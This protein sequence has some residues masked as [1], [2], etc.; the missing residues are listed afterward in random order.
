MGRKARKYRISC[1]F[2]FYGQDRLKREITYFIAKELG[3]AAQFI[4][5]NFFYLLLER[6]SGALAAPE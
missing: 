4:A 3:A 1:F 5:S 2:V 6:P